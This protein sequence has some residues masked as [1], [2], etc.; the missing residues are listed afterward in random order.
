M[1]FDY[2]VAHRAIYYNPA[3][4]VKLP[5]GLVRGKRDAPDDMIMDTVLSNIGQPFGFF[6]FLLLCTGLRKSEALALQ[7]SDIDLSA[8]VIRV[9]KSI[10]YFVGSKPK[11]KTP[12]TEMGRREVPIIDILFTELKKRYDTRCSDYLFPAADSNRAGKGGGLMT[13][14]GYEGEWRRYCLALGLIDSDGNMV[15]TAH[16][17]RHGTATLL[18]E[19][20]VDVLTAQRILGHSKPETT[21]AIYTALREKQA[22]KSISKM[23]VGMSRRMSKVSKEA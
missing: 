19:Y 2:A 18:F 22:K 13:E 16:H 9:T 8:K 3:I 6:P 5:K 14:R 11:Y 23:N 7:W 15:I 12:K 21:Q 10:D 4:G 1:I 17:M 20:G